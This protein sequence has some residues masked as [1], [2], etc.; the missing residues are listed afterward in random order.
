LS[1]PADVQTYYRQITDLDIGTLAREMLGGRITQESGATLFC[2]CP[3]HRSQ[4][5]R[6]LQVMLDKQGWYCFACGVG[7]DVLQLV[8]FVHAGTVTRGQSGVMPES[9]R[10][11]RDFLAARVGLPPLA[12][13]GRSPEEIA[14]AEEEHRLTWRVREALAALAEIYHQRLLANAEV[15]AWFKSKYGIGDA[16]IRSLKIGFAENEPGP[17]RALT[18]GVG[19]FTLRELSATSA[20]RPTAQDGL[21]PFFEGR[22]VFPYWSRGNVVFMIGRRTP[23][24]PDQEWEKS[25]Y[26]KLPVRNDRNNEHVAQCI[27]NDVLF[28][29][30]VLLMRPERVIITEGVTDCISLMEH[31]FPVVSPVTVRIRE[32]D[33]ERLLPKLAGVKTVFICQDNEISEA[34]LNGA[35]KTARILGANG[36]ATRV[37]VLPLGEKQRAAREKLA[38][39]AA[40]C[41]EADALLADAKI[42]VNEFFASGKS[43]ADF[44]ET[45][46]AAQTPLELAISKL[47]TETPDQSLSRCLEPILAE[48]GRL[49]PIEQDRHLRLIQAHC[50]KER[51]PV[52]TLRKQLKVVEIDRKARPGNGR[53]FAFSAAGGAQPAPIDRPK[54]A[55]LPNIQL[56]NRQLQDVIADSWSAIHAANQIEPP[57]STGKPFLFQ[58]GGAL[59]RIAEASDSPTIE[60]MN[61][62]SMYGVL[63]RTANWNRAIGDLVLDT[64][65]SKDV[66][67]DLLVN[68]DPNL[69]H[70]ESLIRTPVFGK[71]GSLLTESGY[72]QADRL[73]LIPDTSLAVPE[74]PTKPTADQI[75][76]ARSLLLDDLLVDFPFVTPADRAHAV[77][78][79]ILPFIRR[80]IDGA[81][82]IHLVEAPTM[83]SGKGLLTNLI[84]IVTTGATCEAR[85]IP[86]HEDEIR[87]ML[88]AELINGRPITLLDNVSDKKKLDSSALASIITAPRWTDRYLG[89]SR[90]VTVPNNA[91]WLMTGNNPK[92]S[93][94][95]TRRCVRL[96]IDPRV[97]R[98]WLRA[99]FKHAAIADWAKQNRSALVHAVLTLVQAWIAAGR[100][101]HSVLLG[102]FEPWSAILGG[103]LGVA[104]IPGFL[105]NLNELY[106]NADA[107]G[108]MWREFI[109]AWWEN[110]HRTP[111]KVSDLNRLCEQHDLML[112]VR[113]DGSARSQQTRL[114]T[115][116]GNKRDRVFNGLSVKRVSFNKH[117]GAFLYALA[118]VD[119]GGDPSQGEQSSLGLIDPIE[120]ADLA[121]LMRTSVVQGPPA[122]SP[123]ET[124]TSGKSADLADLIPVSHTETK[125][126]D[127][128]IRDI[129]CRENSTRMEA[130]DTAEVRQVRAILATHTNDSTYTRRTSGAEVRT[131]SAAGSRGPIDLA[132]LPE[133]WDAPDPN[134][135]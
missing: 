70:L 89:E 115:G 57:P 130:P 97:D 73:W 131:R 114:A 21:F 49:D 12:Q 103:V 10:E 92:L 91:L 84:S 77:A 78:A 75:S 4:S 67:R 90:M 87:K 55:P 118:P 120:S 17:V 23:W 41:A 34:G 88:T 50:G 107:D 48:V 39:L 40:D 100:P 132:N 102:S 113:G 129:A 133:E 16:T 44:E 2:D 110:F 123:I 53:S 8:E 45:L 135:P 111:Q 106:E 64:S 61:E 58:R 124:I 72:H 5:H 95:M 65:P 24:T 22:I 35:L 42:D 117:K 38:G 7:G 116:L 85:T 128:H 31:G 96:R 18:N 62:T 20:F 86:A 14:E 27:Q 66:A 81:T 82:P 112:S 19:A 101:L 71:D 74:V 13:M 134:P 3:N 29:E 26:K 37:A 125:L 28:N 36:I 30:D 11:A 52:T 9:H 47:S 32:A 25:K 63:A 51:I 121:D 46:S 94:E 56:N 1:T 127:T 126:N 6:S 83:G 60:H 122:L 108:Q 99:K 69:P 98:P 33:W 104:Q 76:A 68:P 93:D 54:F 119:G 80:M 105:G 109:A 43:A 59:V 15:L 79:V